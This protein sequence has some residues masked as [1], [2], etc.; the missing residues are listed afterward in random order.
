MA[1]KFAESAIIN[2]I[3]YL[4][5]AVAK[6]SRKRYIKQQGLFDMFFPFMNAYTGND[7]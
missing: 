4:I 2:R 3:F 6:I 5:L 1:N 7:C